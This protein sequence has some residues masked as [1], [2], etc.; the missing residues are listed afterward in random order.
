MR[1]PKL[2]TGAIEIDHFIC[3]FFELEGNKYRPSKANLKWTEL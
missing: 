1:D 2:P 3:N